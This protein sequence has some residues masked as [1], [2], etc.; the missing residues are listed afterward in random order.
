MAYLNFNIDV[1]ALPNGQYRVTVQS[2]IGQAS[3][4]LNPPFTPD[5]LE[6]PM[7]IFNRTR[8]VS[9]QLEQQIAIQF[10]S[11][12]FDF[13]IRGSSDINAA[14]LTSLDRAGTD[15]LRLRLS[16]DRAGDLRLLPWEFLRD[17]ARDFV[18][19]SRTTPIVRYAQGLS[20]RPPAPVTLPL[21]VLVVIS[22][23]EDHAKLDVEGEWTRL[24]EATAELR[25]NKLLE[26]E[27]LEKATLIALQRRLRREVFHVVHYVGHSDYDD[28]EGQ[29]Y[30]VFEHETDPTKSQI[31]SGAAL[32][33][34]LGEESTI[35]LIVLNSCQSGHP[36]ERDWLAGIT[37]N[38]V[39]RG[40]PAVVAMQFAIT[41]GSAKVFSE[42][43]YRAIAE[44]LPIDTAVSEAR[45]AIANR[46]NNVEWATPVLYMRSDDGA[47]FEQKPAST[48]GVTSPDPSPDRTRVQPTTI[49]PLI[50]IIAALVVLVI[51]GLL[52]LR[53]N[54][55]PPITPTPEPPTP[56]TPP[57]LRPDLRIGTVRVAPSRPGPGQIFRVSV[58][59]TNAGGVDSGP[60]NWTWDASLT[61]PVQQNSQVGRVENI[62]P[63]STRNIS[64]PFSYGWWGVYSSQLVAD[65]DSEIEEADER[66][67]RLPFDI[68]IANLPFDIDF[69]LLPN[70]E[71]TVPPVRFISGGDEFDPWNLVVAVNPLD[72]PQCAEVPLLITDLN[73]DIV[74][75]LD[76][77]GFPPEC[78]DLPISIVITRRVISNAVVEVVG[79]QAGQAS[80][81]L[82]GDS[83]G[84]NPLFISG[85][86]P[87]GAGE[88]LAITPGE[89]FGG[90]IRRI[91]VQT[92]G[93]PVN[94]T[95]LVL[96]L[97]GA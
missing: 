43:F 67:N 36:S 20:V 91:D 48:N 69:T 38:L 63:G 95:R 17:P 32:G 88:T 56:T 3:A 11:R 62:P 70:N 52:L 64:F 65:I 18:A 66:N 93:Q 15:G 81:T 60:F 76:T 92:P 29:G 83:A 41:D 42:E 84:T 71:V 33:R 86:L 1:S 8:R 39:A 13:L 35:R 28:A 30:L 40:L 75:R 26:I 6:A 16:V 61:P 59:I 96:V 2:P 23:P 12:L 77:E 82:Y 73:G 79:A 94:L 78:A 68:E 47:L 45:R 9:P 21:R 46:R 14:Y 57:E 5:E 19:L 34:E 10:G 7:A 44:L 22:S 49:S 58:A 24:Q 37:S 31:V 87:V 97:S 85:L 27:R 80:M 4:D 72:R 55:P 53:P 54:D 89:G 25:D 50:G 90:G 74:L 51:A